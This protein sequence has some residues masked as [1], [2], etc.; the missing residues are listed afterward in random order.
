MYVC[1]HMPCVYGCLWRSKK[2][3]RSS[4]TEV[5]ECE[6]GAENQ[7]YFLWEKKYS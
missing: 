3:V 6:M 1:E 7:I 4:G 2:G 5:T